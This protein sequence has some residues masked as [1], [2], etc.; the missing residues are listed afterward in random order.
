MMENIEQYHIVL[1]KIARDG[2]MLPLTRTLAIDLQTKQYLKVGDFFKS[3]SNEDLRTLGDIIEA[4][5]EADHFSEML[6][7]S[8][9]LSQGEGLGVKFES[10]E[11]VTARLNQFIMLVT[12]ESLHRKKLV[13]A[14]HDNFSF[15]DDAKDKI[16][17]EKI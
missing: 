9:M 17:V 2:A 14:Y 7:M 10:I 16:V 1:D 6:L 5:E 12:I 3:L 11:T 8:H 13:K 4:G 15:G